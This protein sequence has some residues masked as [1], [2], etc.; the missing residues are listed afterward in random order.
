MPI[1]WIAE[2]QVFEAKK[3]EAMTAYLVSA[4]NNLR[5][6]LRKALAEQLEFRFNRRGR[7]EK[8]SWRAIPGVDQR[9]RKIKTQVRENHVSAFGDCL[10][11]CGPESRPNP[12]ATASLRR[13]AT[14]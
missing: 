7:K 12:F 2:I 3:I 8:L 5:Y 13:C 10:S 1:E 9:S 11:A 6:L 14:L 4:A